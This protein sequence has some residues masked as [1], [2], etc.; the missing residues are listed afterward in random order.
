MIAHVWL[1]AESVS[2]SYVVAALAV[3][4]G[5]IGSRGC[6]HGLRAVAIGIESRT[7]TGTRRHSGST[8]VSAGI[9]LRGRRTTRIKALGSSIWAAIGAKRLR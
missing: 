9:G 5:E 3:L 2:R 1:L 6:G 4:N 8:S 7:R